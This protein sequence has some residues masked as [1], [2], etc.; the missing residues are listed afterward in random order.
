MSANMH[1]RVALTRPEGSDNCL[2]LTVKGETHTLGNLLR[3]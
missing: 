2:V 3:R 1:K